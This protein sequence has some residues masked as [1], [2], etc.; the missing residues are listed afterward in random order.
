MMNETVKADLQKT[1]MRAREVTPGKMGTPA[2]LKRAR[3]VMRRGAGT[4][5]RLKQTSEVTP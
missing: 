1:T 2:R 4:P 3:E 5:A